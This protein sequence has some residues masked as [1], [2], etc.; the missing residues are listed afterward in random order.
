MSEN[1]PIQND[2]R[3]YLD[4]K[5]VS[6]L[7]SIELKARLVVEGFIVGLH[8]S[9]YHGFSVEFAEHRQYMPGDDFRH[10][11]WKVYGKSD[12][13]YIKQFE[14]ETNLK[15]Y[16]LLDASN[17][18]GFK[19]DGISKLEY[20]SYLAASISYLMLRQQDAPG[21]LVYDEKIRANIPP[22]GARSHINPILIELNQTE[23]SSKTDSSVA[24]H[25]LAERI[26]RRGLVIVI[27]DLLDDP[28]KLLT[29]LKHFRHRQHEVIVFHVLDPYERNFAY[30][31]EARFKD[32]ETGKELLTDPWQIREDYLKNMDK[33]LDFMSRGCRDSH[34]DYH[35][36][37]TSVP[38]DKAL[39]GYLAKR[40]KLG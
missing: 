34:I 11:D 7:S 23:P 36:L 16:I 19:S 3:K 40:S 28:E 6:R 25:E 27:S 2:H 37:D 22:K 17:S 14:E 1:K 20:G 30:S 32:M 39:F 29:G 4:P 8:R 10:I 26:K 21:L 15:G 18:M 24:F 33:F 13:F 31:G 9:P 5:V 35:I 12:R 38:F